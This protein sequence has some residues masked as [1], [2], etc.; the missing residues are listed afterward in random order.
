[1]AGGEAT[2]AGWPGGYLRARPTLILGLTYFSPLSTR[3]MAIR[4]GRKKMNIE[5]RTSNIEY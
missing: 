4:I 2:G 1:M 3:R 5:H